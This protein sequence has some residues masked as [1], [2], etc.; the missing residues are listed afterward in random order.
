M[1]GGSYGGKTQP[2]LYASTWHRL[3]SCGKQKRVGDG[4]DSLLFIDQI[5]PLYVGVIHYIR[6]Q[7]FPGNSGTTRPA[8]RLVAARGG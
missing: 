2:Y 4:P 3:V 5:V 8:T 6:A 1:V 7:I